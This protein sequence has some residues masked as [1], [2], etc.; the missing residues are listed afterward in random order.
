MLWGKKD[1]PGPADEKSTAKNSGDASKME[2]PTTTEKKTAPTP[3]MAPAETRSAQQIDPQA[4]KTISLARFGAMVTVLKQSPH[5][6]KHSLADLDWLVGPAIVLNQFIIVEAGKK[7]EGVTRP[8]GLVTWAKVSP[9]V[10]ARLSKT[11]QASIQLKGEEYNSGDIYWVLM[12]VGPQQILGPTLRTLQEKSFGNKP[13]KIV[14][15][16]EDG[17][18]EA[19]VIEASSPATAAAS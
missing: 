18:F 6:S 1:K 14:L 4:A 5:Y 17:T 10:D 3:K 7:D 19:R 2:E 15:V 8:V 11:P 16:K 12:A 13:Y 9:E